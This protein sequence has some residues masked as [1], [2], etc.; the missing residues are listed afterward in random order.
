MKG[1]T[2]EFLHY[3]VELHGEPTKVPLK[4]QIILMDMVS[5]HSFSALSHVSASLISYC[6]HQTISNKH[7]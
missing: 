4:P 3:T 2:A 1:V 5:I 7:S 6:E